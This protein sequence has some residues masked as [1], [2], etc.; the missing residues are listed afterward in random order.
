VFLFPYLLGDPE[1][2]SVADPLKTPL[3]IQ[4]EW[5]FLFAYA[6][7][8]SVP[9]KLGG[10]IFLLLSI[11]VLYFL[12]FFSFEWSSYFFLK[13]FFFFYFS[14]RFFILTWIGMRV[15]EYPYDLVGGLFRF[16]YFFFFSL[17]KT[18]KKKKKKKIKKSK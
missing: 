16:L 8:R 10:V 2:F 18:K 17:F 7:L 6:I 12:C 11:L 15:V 1:N 5:Y 9:S 3:H 4:P 14:G 13:R